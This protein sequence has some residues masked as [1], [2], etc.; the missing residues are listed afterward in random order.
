MEKEAIFTKVRI[1]VKATAKSKFHKEGEE[2]LC[3]PTVAE[4]LLKNGVIAK[5]K[6]SDVDDAVNAEKEKVKELK[7]NSK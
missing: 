5:Y 6:E 3:A 4:K 2:F 7:K 1:K